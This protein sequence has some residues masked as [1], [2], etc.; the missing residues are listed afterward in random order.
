M[1]KQTYKKAMTD[2]WTDGHPK[3]S[4]TQHYLDSITVSLFL[5]VNIYN[6]FM[7]NALIIRR[8]DVGVHLP[9]H[10]ILA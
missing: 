9:Q 8:T 10:N 1:I 3:T 7:F 2:G 6:Y 5:Q 4:L